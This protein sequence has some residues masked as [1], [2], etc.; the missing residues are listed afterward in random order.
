M[1]QQM[2][3]ILFLVFV[4]ASFNLY[5]QDTTFYDTNYNKVNNITDASYYEIV[6]RYYPDTNRAIEKEYYKSGKLKSWN[7]YS[8]YFYR[9]QHGKQLKF[10]PDGQRATEIDIING[11]FQGLL[12]TWYDNG[13][14]RRKDSFYM[15]SLIVGHCYTR[16]GVDT[17]YFDYAI[18]PGFPGGEEA[19]QEF[20]SDKI[21]YPA[22]A[23]EN[24]IQGMVFISFIVEPDGSVSNVEI[25]NGN[26]ELSGEALRVVKL[27]PKWNPGYFEGEKAKVKINMPINF[28]IVD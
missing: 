7:Q 11:K 27:M 16:D 6:T 9:I 22:K 20:L 26:K 17:A 21:I 24:G 19:R 8:I 1:I 13:Q 28:V 3:R 23:L 14:L 12:K 18:Q 2:K 25:L 5:G 15:D 10:Y 4:I